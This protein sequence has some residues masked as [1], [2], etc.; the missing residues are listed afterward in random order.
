[1][2]TFDLIHPVY[3]GFLNQRIKNILN[4]RDS[5]PLL[6]LSFLSMMTHCHTVSTPYHSHHSLVNLTERSHHYY[7]NKD[8]Q[9]LSEG[10]E[11]VI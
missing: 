3:S 5:N 10:T 2:L 6:F 8:S 4:Q 1:M 7:L 11:G 9:T